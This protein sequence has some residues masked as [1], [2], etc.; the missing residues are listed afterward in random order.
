MRPA[1][2]RPDLA[3]SHGRSD[4][5]FLALGMVG[6]TSEAEPPR[7]CMRCV[8][9]DWCEVSRETVS[10]AV[11]CRAVRC[12]AAQCR[13]VQRSA[14]AVQ[15]SAVQCAVCSVQYRVVAWRVMPDGETSTSS[16]CSI[17]SALLQCAQSVLDGWLAWSRR[18]F[19]SLCFC[20]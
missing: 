7:D 4:S 6:T 3:G 10:R 17:P 2:P 5:R 19:N 16:C 12:S 18:P 9:K 15:H 1:L 11:Q 13:A 8:P 14:C 20:R